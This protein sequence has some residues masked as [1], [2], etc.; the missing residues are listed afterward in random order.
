MLWTVVDQQALLE[1]SEEIKAPKEYVYQNK[2]ILGYPLSE[3]RVII[4]ALIS[5]NP[6]DY[7]N[8]SY[9]PGKIIH[10]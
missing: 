9:Y 4:S 1:H 5:S 2:L 10:I 3:N 6:G 8:P 7:L